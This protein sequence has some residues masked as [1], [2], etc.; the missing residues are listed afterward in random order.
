[1]AAEYAKGTEVSAS[2]TL[3]EI[4][5]LLRRYGAID[6][7]Q[8]ERQGYALLSFEMRKRIVHFAVK[9]PDVTE[10]R[11]K[12]TNHNPPR[13]RTLSATREAAEAER[14]RLWRAL[15]LTIKAKL[16]SVASGIEQFE[17]AFMAQLVMPDGQTVERHLLPK[18]LEAYDENGTPPLQ[19]P[20]PP[21]KGNPNA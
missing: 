1:M 14:R 9:L 12:W 13:K 15:L 21:E 4:Q 20:A 16:E 10:E 6:F 2:Q 17:A 18:I 11:F 7:I 5:T 3:A 8:G 19:L